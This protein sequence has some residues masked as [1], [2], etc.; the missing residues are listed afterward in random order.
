MTDHIVRDAE[1]D[2]V[3]ETV[4]RAMLLV[5]PA[6][7]GVERLADEQPVEEAAV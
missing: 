5:G 1:V 6:E 2:G 4:R 7:S 3:A